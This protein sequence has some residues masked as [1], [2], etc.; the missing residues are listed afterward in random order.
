MAF[1]GEPKPRALWV[2]LNLEQT[3]FHVVLN[4][5]GNQVDNRTFWI[6]CGG[7]QELAM[8]EQ[9]AGPIEA[10]NLAA[11]LHDH[12]YG[13][14]SDPLTHFACAL[15]AL[16]HDADH[17]GVPNS[18]LI[19]EQPLLGERY[20]NRSVA[21]QNSFDLAWDLLMQEDFASLRTTL[22]PGPS[23]LQ[24][25]RQLVINSVMATDIPINL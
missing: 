9:E 19:V 8:P 12:T 25:L 2:R 14:T 15:S 23:D 6:T 18:R 10:G 4:H 20:K 16:I 3:L 24:R 1:R 17:R 22:C 21:E 13:I 11:K 5:E 7:E